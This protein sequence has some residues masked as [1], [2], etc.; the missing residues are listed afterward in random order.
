VLSLL[1]VVISSS[2]GVSHCLIADRNA[3]D[4]SLQLNPIP[5]GPTCWLCCCPC[6]PAGVP[7]NALY[8]VTWS[9]D[10]SLLAASSAGG[11]VYLFDYAKG[12][13]LKKWQLHD[14]PSLKVRV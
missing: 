3:C 6:A 13:A 10:C 5:R 8:S 12:I 7:S 11:A 1:Q 9:P 14:K 4:M 2:G